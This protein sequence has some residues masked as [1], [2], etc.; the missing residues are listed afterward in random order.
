MSHSIA[1]AAT[2]LHAV[3]AVVPVCRAE[4]EIRTFLDLPLITGRHTA[5]LPGA[6]A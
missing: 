4:P 6:R 3:H 2:A 1:L 5:G